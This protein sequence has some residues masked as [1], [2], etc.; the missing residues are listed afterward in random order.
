[1]FKIIGQP[2]N[3]RYIGNSQI[4]KDDLSK[5]VQQRIKICEFGLKY[6][7]KAAIDGFE[8]SKSTYYN[9]LKH[10]KLSKQYSFPLAIKSKRP[11]NIRKANWNQ[12]VVKCIR[13]LRSDHPNIGKVKIKYYLDILCEKLKL[14][15]ISTGTIQNIINSYPNKLRTMKST[16]KIQRREGVVRK[17]AKYKASKSGECTA[18]DSME[19]RQGGKKLYVVVAQDEATNL[20]YARA[21]NSHTSR[22]AKEILEL[23][24][25]YLPWSKYNIILTDNGSEFGKDF[26]KYVEEQNAIHYHTYPKTPQQNA[27]C[28][29]VNRTIQDEFMIKYGNL[30]FDDIHRF[31]K[32]LDEYLHWYNFK[33][34]HARFDNKMTP[35]ERHRELARDGKIID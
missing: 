5:E 21:T 29:R 4:A 23:A 11:N 9:Y 15:P 28:E 31:N 17:P 25:N 7:Y 35:F 18:L 1:M 33:R 6:G 30:L 26:A 34:V 16:L 19:F 20:L 32:K 12:R 14:K 3:L 13:K 24:H 2:I 8:I 27:R 22:S 10:Y